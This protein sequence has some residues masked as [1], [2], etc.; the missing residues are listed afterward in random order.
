MR[1]VIT[2][3][4]YKILLEQKNPNI[5]KAYNEI[6]KGANYILGTSKD[7]IL[8][9]FNYIK[10]S[11]DF[12]TLL[13]MFKDKKTGYS[14]FEEMINEEYDRFDYNDIIKLQE[15]LYSI[16]VVLNFKRGKNKFGTLLFM[17]GVKITYEKNFKNTK[18]SI[19]VNSNCTSKYTPLLKQAQDYWRKWLSNPITK[20]KFRTNWNVQP[21]TDTV[22]GKKVDDIFE[23]YFDC[24]DNLKLVFYDNTMIHP[25]GVSE[26][27]VNNSK[28]AYAFVHHA[29]PENI[30]VNC[31]LDNEDPLGTLIH[32][33]QH[34]LYDIKPLNPEITIGNVFLKPGDKKLKIKDILGDFESYLKNNAQHLTNIASSLGVNVDKLNTW[35]W[36]SDNIKPDDPGY[37]CR[38]TEKASNIQSV[39]HLLNIKPGQNI[40]PQM[41][42][43]Y[44]ND[45]KNNTDIDWLLMCW[46]SKGFKD[47][48]LFL[49]D[50]NKLAYQ[51]TKP[52][53]NTRLA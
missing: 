19:R 5:Q 8:G 44:I 28:R 46:A 7:T 13:S 36:R 4:Q 38:E 31:S 42:K 47:I 9:A 11:S 25:P 16:G 39:R 32:E 24:I 22:D 2:E 30:Y 41:L 6:V 23:E 27:D 26:I 33:I 10:N 45:E 1:I 18:K 50:L 37:V 35:E 15:K 52:T 43:P 53:D 17:G 14:S 20:Q 12:K 3:S 48:N 21:K 29:T 49:S 34:L 51:E 40:T